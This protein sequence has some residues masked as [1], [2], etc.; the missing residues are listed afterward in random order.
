MDK[1]NFHTY[2]NNP[3]LLQNLDKKVL[4]D[5]VEE[6]PFC[7]NLRFLLL[8]KAQ[9][10]NSPEFKSILHSTST[11]APDRAFLFLKMQS[12]TGPIQIQAT[13]KV[14][15]MEDALEFEALNSPIPVV[16]VPE[17][18]LNS[19]VV[20]FE[21]N[22]E[23]E[24]ESDPI[25]HHEENL[26][27]AEIVEDVAINVP[28][29]ST[30]QNQEVA[31]KIIEHPKESEVILEIENSQEDKM[32]ILEQIMTTN[33]EVSE[34][35]EIVEE[36]VVEETPVSKEINT[37]QQSNNLID[38]KD[39][40]MEEKKPI[41][42][43][44]RIIRETRIEKADGQIIYPAKNENSNDNA[45]KDLVKTQSK[46]IS[47]AKAPK[48]SAE[49]EIQQPEEI[50]ANEAQVPTKQ[51]IDDVNIDSRLKMMGIVYNEEKELPKLETSKKKSSKS[52]TKAKQEVK[53]VKAEKKNKKGKKDKKDK[54]KK[55]LK[56]FVKK[57]VSMQKEIASETLAEI[58]VLQQNYKH[59]IEMYKRLS[60]LYPENRASYQ[61][62][63][64]K[65]KK[66]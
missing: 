54:H 55:R 50:N 53:V 56:E 6:Y 47:N 48:V 18:K 52:K 35:E 7:Q 16:N 13:P 21:F 45:L 25:E 14:Q 9:L 42:V 37:K 24:E 44:K 51:S 66:I 31:P 63:I 64:Q 30:I 36:D 28:K 10:D 60:D 11:Y 33:D 39:V 32:S 61:Q 41:R 65:L 12:R 43:I 2:L 58:L 27:E 26:E 23:K 57:S 38:K 40:K 20:V 59:A 46:Q 15:Y 49:T 22:D 1:S 3:A 34:E 5:L 62:I 29:A 4:Q 19:K 17:N 8:K